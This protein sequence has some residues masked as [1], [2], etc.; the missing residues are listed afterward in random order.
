MDD[1]REWAERPSSPH[2]SEPD[3]P[4]EV[5]DPGTRIGK[6]WSVIPIRPSTTGRC[7]RCHRALILT[8]S[9]MLAAQTSEDDLI[10]Y[11]CDQD[12]ATTAD[13][14]HDRAPKARLSSVEVNR[15]CTNQPGVRP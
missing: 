14:T 7:R 11:P 5:V 13:R 4:R 6:L 3:S 1:G 12:T 10:C 8:E 2:R 15:D 9:E